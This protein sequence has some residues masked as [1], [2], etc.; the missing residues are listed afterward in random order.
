MSKSVIDRPLAE[1][2]L[3][4]IKIGTAKRYGEQCLQ[5]ELLVKPVVAKQVLKQ[6]GMM[7]EYDGI[8]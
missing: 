3:N 8:Q 7:Q 6:K 2:R 1:D 4:K 5:R